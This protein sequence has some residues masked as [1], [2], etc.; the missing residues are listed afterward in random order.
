[1]AINLKSAFNIRRFFDY[2]PRIILRSISKYSLFNI[3]TPFFKLF[4]PHF[5]FDCLHFGDYLFRYLFLPETLDFIIIKFQ[6]VGNLPCCLVILKHYL[7]I[8]EH[9][10]CNLQGD[11]HLLLHLSCDIVSKSPFSTGAA[12]KAE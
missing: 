1:M 11:M 3:L 4:S 7:E 12:H 5:S 8:R 6:E 2:V 10:I 9:G